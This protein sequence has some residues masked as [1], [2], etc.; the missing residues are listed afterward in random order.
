M[1]LNAATDYAIR[2]TLYLA[3]KSPNDNAVSATNLSCALKKSSRYLLQIGASLRDA[4][5][6]TVIHG[7]SGGYKLAKPP[8]EIS[9]HSIILLME[10]SGKTSKL[11]NTQ[12]LSE[13]EMFQ[14]LEIA[15]DYLDDVIANILKSITIENLMSQKI[16]EWYLAPCLL[17]LRESHTP[18]K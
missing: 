1:K 7:P 15:Y 5:I 3:H 2:M 4:G 9:L 10:R 14:T 6:V 12:E 11:K 13:T 17:K 18:K 8:G 16:D